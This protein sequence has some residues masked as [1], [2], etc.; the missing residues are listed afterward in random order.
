MSVPLSGRD[1][2]RREESHSYSTNEIFQGTQRQRI[3][4]LFSKWLPRED[5][6]SK[7]S[8]KT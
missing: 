2:E 5:L 6:V 3:A 8:L 1:M 4:Q 7:S